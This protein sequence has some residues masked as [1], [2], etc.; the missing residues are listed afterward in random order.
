MAAIKII[1]ERT[2]NGPI[3]DIEDFAQRFTKSEVGK[4]ELISLVLAG[5]LDTIYKGARKD[6]LK[7]MLT[8]RGYS[9]D[10]DEVIDKT[11]PKSATGKDAKQLFSKSFKDEFEESMRISMSEMA[12]LGMYMTAHPLRGK[13]DTINW[14]S[15]YPG[16]IK[17]AT[18]VIT[19]IKKLKIKNGYNAGKDMAIVKV[20]TLEGEKTFTIFSQVY[21]KCSNKLEEGGIRTF[22]I[23]CERDRRDPDQMSYL[24][25][26]IKYFRGD[27]INENVEIDDQREC[28]RLAEEA[29]L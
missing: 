2:T 28:I 29:L 9:D 22:T 7:D 1:K 4:R 16:D 15:L 25:N 8:L 14:N 11:L 20:D 5:A 23:K 17:D 26:N 18:G 13:V 21:D 19:N 3:K 6:L 12:H 27:I 24:V 10:V